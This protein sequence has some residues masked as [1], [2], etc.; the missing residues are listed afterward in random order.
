[1]NM[2]NKFMPNT[3]WDDSKPRYQLNDI[4]T[5]TFAYDILD[6]YEDKCCD[7][8]KRGRIIEIICS[9][10]AGTEPIYNYRV[11]WDSNIISIVEEVWLDLY[12]EDIMWNVSFT[13]R[14]VAE[15]ISIAEA[16]KKYDPRYK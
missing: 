10:T 11:S 4:V 3:N 9:A 12:D 7:N 14:S 2:G 6:D 16:Q 8:F 13:M 15:D 1:M 5:N